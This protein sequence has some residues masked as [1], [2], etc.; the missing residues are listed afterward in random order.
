M[1]TIDTKGLAG[2]GQSMRTIDTKGLVSGGQSMRTIDTKGLAGGGQS[3]RTIA[4]KGLA[5]GG[6]SMRTKKCK[7]AMHAHADA[8]RFERLVAGSADFLVMRLACGV[9]C[10]SNE[11]INFL[12]PGFRLVIVVY[13]CV[14]MHV[15]VDRGPFEAKVKNNEF[16]IRTQ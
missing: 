1:R 10:C 4:T 7:T 11:F 2:G 6:Q 12:I 14:C 9:M 15:C 5:G 8:V 3:M 16:G 13:V